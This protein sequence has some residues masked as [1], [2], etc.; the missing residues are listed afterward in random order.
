MDKL[1]P[2]RTDFT[3]R[4]AYKRE[5]SEYKID[6]I[7][8]MASSSKKISFSPRQS[9]SSSSESSKDALSSNPR[10]YYR[11]ESSSSS[12]GFTEE[13]LGCMSQVD[14]QWRMEQTRKQRLLMAAQAQNIERPLVRRHIPRPREQ[15]HQRL[16]EDYFAPDCLYPDRTFRR[17]FRMR[18]ELFMR[19]ANAVESRNE[20]FVQ[21]RDAVG[22]LGLSPLQKITTA[23]RILAYGCSA[24]H[25][26]EYIK[27]GQ[28]TAIATL[29]EF[30]STMIELFEAQY[31]R[32]PTTEDIARLLEEGVSRGF[33]GM[34]GSLDCMHW[35]W[36]NCPVGWH[37]SH[38]GRSHKA[39]LILEAVASRD[40]WIWHAFFGMAGGNNDLNVLDHSPV[41]D[42]F[43]QGR[44]PPTN[45]IVN[46]QQFLIGYYLIDGIYP[47]YASFVQTI[48]PPTT[49][50]ERL[51]TQKQ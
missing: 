41:F 23:V 24:D 30:C 5:P 43:L 6:I 18:R 22:R 29:K 50:K 15:S 48:N 8:S 2:R 33:P 40:L 37:G 13:F 39:T 42:E 19:I 47:K 26:D 21:K 51:F 17:R 27:I 3:Q 11:S 32:S 44:T 49:A 20:Y 4:Y 45:Y 35:E 14:L 25:C 31:L 1:V 16:W 46:G 28:S 34:L 9:S 7:Q 38:K 36:K 10:Q 12:G